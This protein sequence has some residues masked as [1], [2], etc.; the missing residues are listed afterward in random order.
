MVEPRGPRLVGVGLGGG[1]LAPDGVGVDPPA[2]ID[3]VVAAAGDP[4]HLLDA[5]CR[6]APRSPAAGRASGPRGPTATASWN[7][8]AGLQRVGDV[9]APRLGERER[10][11]PGVGGRAGDGGGDP[12]GPGRAAP[13]TAA[14][15]TPPP[16]RMPML[17]PAP[18]ARIPS[19]EVI[20]RATGGVK[21]RSRSDSPRPCR[22]EGYGRATDL[23][24]ADHGDEDLVDRAGVAGVVERPPG[25]PRRS[26]GAWRGRRPR[27]RRSGTPARPGPARPRPGRDS[28]E[29]ELRELVAVVVRLAVVV[30]AVGEQHHRVD[31]RGVVLV[32]LRARRRPAVAR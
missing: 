23:E 17:A 13:S 18:R 14:P 21:N 9:A 2:G 32:E 22:G 4:P 30:H 12:S 20:A 28:V 31:P 19:G 29:Q 3:E 11:D 26:G 8:A 7:R 6:P 5:R 25:W 1:D 10:V 16:A 24:V 15:M 27:R